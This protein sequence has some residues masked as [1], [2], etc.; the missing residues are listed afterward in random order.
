MTRR[1]SRRFAALLLSSLLAGGMG[2]VPA[3]AQV[4]ADKQLIFDLLDRIERLESD[5]RQLRGSLEVY[6]HRQE[7]L[8]LRLADLEAVKRGI[9]ASRAGAPAEEELAP[10]L[11]PEPALSSTP[12]LEAEVPP[13]DT[14]S[15]RP[16]RSTASVAP[17]SEQAAYDTAFN[18]LREGHFEQ[19]V[20]NFQEFLR[21]Y[22]NSRLAGNAQYWL[23]EAYYVTR[24][25]ENAKQAFINLGVSYPNSDKVPDAL[26]KLGYIYGELG[27]KA[28]AR[29]ILNKVMQAYPGSQAA[30]LAQKRLSLLK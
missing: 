18:M 14:P 10:E 2:Y 20:A 27:D 21:N 13:A 16:N 8:E 28:K 19:S 9:G 22:P 5:I 29:E 17:A 11:A 26:L 7:N 12:P 25:F 3:R 24:D 23:G 6:R 1:V 4:A 15:S 30:S